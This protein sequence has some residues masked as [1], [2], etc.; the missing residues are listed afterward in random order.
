MSDFKF[1]IG[2]IDCGWLFGKVTLGGAAIEFR[3][4]SVLGDDLCRLLLAALTVY[5]ERKEVENTIDSGSYHEEDFPRDTVRIDEEGTIV[6]W[7]I[8]RDE[9]REIVHVTICAERYDND[10][11]E[12]PVCL[13][14]DVTREEF[15][16][17]IVAGIDKWLHAHG[18]TQYY[19]RWGA[20]FP[21]TEF[22]TAKAVVSG[23]ELFGNLD[24]DLALL[25]ATQKRKGGKHGPRR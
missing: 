24:D 8:R 12:A 1:E 17:A 9:A 10:G 3:M 5:S 6:E 4:S 15:V 13:R 11:N 23:M 21:L 20:P 25:A 19:R 16:S 14:G 18:L 7:K 22:M 2:S